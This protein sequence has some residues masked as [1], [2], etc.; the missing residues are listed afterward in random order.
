MLYLL[1]N[2]E[3]FSGEQTAT[4]RALKDELIRVY[5]SAKVPEKQILP[6]V[7]KAV[8]GLI[9]KGKKIYRGLADK[10]Q[11]SARID[12]VFLSEAATKGGKRPLAE[13][14]AA[15]LKE[16]FS[17]K[18][19]PKKPKAEKKAEPVKKKAEP[20]KELTKKAG[21]ISISELNPLLAQIDNLQVRSMLRK[22]GELMIEYHAT[23]QAAYKTA[24]DRIMATFQKYVKDLDAKATES[25]NKVVEFIKT[26]DR[27][28]K[29]VESLRRELRTIR[30]QGSTIGDK[31][32]TQKK[33]NEKLAPED[34][35]YWLKAG[36]LVGL[37]LIGFVAKNYVSDNA[38][39]GGK[40]NYVLKGGLVIGLLA[41]GYVGFKSFF[42]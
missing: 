4:G 12:E 13:A 39:E 11:I 33:I 21:P 15:F 3:G 17:R 22:Y 19:P 10:T 6:G 36:L 32:E 7:D 8:A 24:A 9:K 1:C 35:Q 25:S 27:T 37:V 41:I 23:G 2:Q 40:S 38:P 34:P 31:Y 42:D 26:Y 28:N 14:A 29:G 5:R 20:I 16:Y 18:Y 30:A